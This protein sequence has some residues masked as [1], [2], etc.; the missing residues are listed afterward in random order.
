[1][2]PTLPSP[3]EPPPVPELPP[4]VAESDPAKPSP[5]EIQLGIVM[6]LLPLTLL[7]QGLIGFAIPVGLNVIAPLVFWLMKKNESRHLDAHG[8]E[9]VNFNI[10]FSIVMVILWL[11]FMLLFLIIIGFIFVPLM[12]LLGIAWLV[13]TVI[14]AIQA[15]E[16]KLFRYPATI[17]FIR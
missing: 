11:L 1:M 10:T 6:H 8:K 16:G 12:V 3:P 15:S 7:L 13:L 9:V 5:T 14:G 4:L 17:R 2:D